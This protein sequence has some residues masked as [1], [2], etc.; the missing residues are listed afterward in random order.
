MAVHYCV[1]KKHDIKLCWV[2][3]TGEKVNKSSIAFK[4]WKCMFKNIPKFGCHMELTTPYPLIIFDVIT[5][6]HVW[7]LF[8]ASIYLFPF[9]VSLHIK[10]TSV[11]NKTG[12]HDI[13]FACKLSKNVCVLEFIILHFLPFIYH[14]ALPLAMA[15]SSF[16]KPVLLEWKPVL[17]PQT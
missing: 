17:V 14:S 1:D 13:A 12:L 6:F 9:L 10:K 11:K 4:K 2:L 15:R 8:I 16:Y 3:A 7:C 5:T